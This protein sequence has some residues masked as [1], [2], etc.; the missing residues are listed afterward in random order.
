MFLYVYFVEGIWT[1]IELETVLVQR[2]YEAMIYYSVTWKYW[3][4]HVK[5]DVCICSVLFIML[6]EV[7]WEHEV[8]KQ[9]LSAFA[10]INLVCKDY[11]KCT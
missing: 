11:D 9:D 8:M 2:A 10:I 5:F 3:T 1:N 7:K 6:Q 4:R